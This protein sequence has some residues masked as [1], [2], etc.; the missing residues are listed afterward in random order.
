MAIMA[1]NAT[2]DPAISLT[3]RICLAAIFARSL[4]GKLRDPKAFVAAIRN[5]EMVPGALAAGMAAGFLAVEAL[6]VPL[7]F[8]AETT[9]L[10]S[11]TAAGL[12]L[13]YSAAIGINL[14]RGRRDI[15]CGCSGPRARQPLHE[16]L[17]FRNAFLTAL[18][19]TASLPVASRHLGG[20]DA[21]T[22][23]FAATSLLALSVATDGLAALAARTRLQR[24]PR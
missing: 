18:A 16:G 9:R 6:L 7:L 21:M 15:D 12:L 20:I 3:L 24:S 13:V 19:M 14:W 1:A 2:L 23:G 4:Y 5:Y 17:L 11:L 8:V 10:A 22:I